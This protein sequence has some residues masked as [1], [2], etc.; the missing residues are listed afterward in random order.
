MYKGVGYASALGKWLACAEHICKNT[1][2]FQTG[3]TD[4]DCKF[5][6]IVARWPGGTHDSFISQMSE[7][8]YHLE[9][10]HTTLKICIKRLQFPK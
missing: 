4:A 6:D 8:K 9:R 3:L 5:A 1:P 2:G 7:V 10:N